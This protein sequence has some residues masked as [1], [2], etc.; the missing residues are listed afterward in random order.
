MNSKVPRAGPAK[1]PLRIGISLR[2][3]AF[4]LF[5]LKKLSTMLPKVA[6]YTLPPKPWINLAKIATVK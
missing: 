3:K 4:I 2:V 1:T 6:N 5:L